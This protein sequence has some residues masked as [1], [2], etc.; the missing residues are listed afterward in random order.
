[1]R[2][3]TLQLDGISR[4]TYQT[5]CN[6]ATAWL[7]NV[8]GPYSVIFDSA[9]DDVLI[10]YEARTSTVALTDGRPGLGHDNVGDHGPYRGGMYQG[11]ASAPHTST[12]VVVISTCLLHSMWPLQAQ[13]QAYHGYNPSCSTVFKRGGDFASCDMFH[14]MQVFHYKG[15][16]VVPVPCLILT[17]LL[18]GLTSGDFVSL[19]VPVHE[20]FTWFVIV[21]GKALCFPARAL[22]ADSVAALIEAFA[23]SPICQHVHHALPGRLDLEQTE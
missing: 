2:L 19:T 5:Y 20:A 15:S 17:H 6:F 16:T 23:V 3:V 14:C 12:S 1:M 8:R 4:R 22:C 18:T 11:G 9:L 7:S 10:I 13:Q 21:C